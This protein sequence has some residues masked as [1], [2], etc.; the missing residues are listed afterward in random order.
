V[1]PLRIVKDFGISIPAHYCQ[2]EKLFHPQCDFFGIFAPNLINGSEIKL[3]YS[4]IKIQ[5]NEK[6]H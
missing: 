2:N 3:N 6:N 5:N 1:L 4:S